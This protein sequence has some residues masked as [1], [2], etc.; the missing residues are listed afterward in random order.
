MDRK[1]LFR[2][3]RG[4]FLFRRER[5]VGHLPPYLYSHVG[6]VRTDGRRTGYALSEE[7]AD[8]PCRRPGRCRRGGGRER[9]AGPCGA[10]RRIPAGQRPAVRQQAPRLGDA[11]AGCLRRGS[12][13]RA[14]RGV[15]PLA[16]G[17]GVR[18]ERA[19]AG[20]RL[21]CEGRRGRTALCGSAARRRL[22]GAFPRDLPGRVGRVPGGFGLSGPQRPLQVRSQC[23]VERRR[24]DLLPCRFLPR[25]SGRRRARARAAQPPLSVQC[26]TGVGSGNAYRRGGAEVGVGQSGGGRRVVERLSGDGDRR[27]DRAVASGAEG[28]GFRRGRLGRLCGRLRIVPA[29]GRERRREPLSGPAGCRR[30]VRP[31]A[32][33][34]QCGRRRLPG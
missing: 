23:F 27:Q 16:L 14:D 10:D 20:R 31:R 33:A 12:G 19:A 17:A 24:N 22:G 8:D 32:S 3:G 18:F 9:Y 26:Q 4:L 2:A 11:P 7:R 15:G 29:A 6:R 28:T 21:R 34:A 13:R 5:G 30:R 1:A 25:R